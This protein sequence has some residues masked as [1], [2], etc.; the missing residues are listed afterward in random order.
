MENRKDYINRIYV[1]SVKLWFSVADN[2]MLHRGHPGVMGSGSN[3]V[4]DE[5]YGVLMGAIQT[6]K[7]IAE[8]IKK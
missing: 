4:F 5:N 6:L 3:E 7:D 1:M 2:N 8:K